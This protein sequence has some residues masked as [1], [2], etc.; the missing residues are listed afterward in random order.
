MR[1]NGRFLLVVA[2]FWFSGY[3]FI[4]YF[5]PYLRQLGIIGTTAGIVLGTYGFSQL[6]LRIPFGVAANRSGNHKAFMLAGFAS[7]V[8]AGVILCFATHPAVFFL[9]RFLAGLA[10]STWVSFTV[11]FTNMHEESETGKAIAAIMIANNCGTLSSYIFGIALFDRLGIGFMF[12]TS[13]A[14]AAAGAALLCTIRD[15]G[16]QAA[17]GGMD[18]RDFLNVIKDKGLILFSSIAALKQIITFATVMSFTPDHVRNSLG[19]SGRE[20]AFLSVVYSVACIC[21]AYWLRTKLSERIPYKYQIACSFAMSAMYCII[22][23]SAGSLWVIYLMQMVGG[24]G[25]AAAMTLTMTLALGDIPQGKRSAAMG[26]YQCV[27]SLGMTLG[28]VFMGGILDVFGQFSYACYAISLIC[29]AGLAFSL[30]A[31]GK[32]RAV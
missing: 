11:F 15:D 18:M 21:G 13:I 26:V 16:K 23:P 10:S 25:Q 3:V 5:T 7:L 4:P 19:A 1:K 31:V 28:P 30:V 9:A 8:I 12:V 24:V 6:V 32:K 17:G 22:V 29:A 20:L 27:Y 2:L 14:A